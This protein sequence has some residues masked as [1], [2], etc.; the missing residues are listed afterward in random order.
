MA[1]PSSP[2][3]THPCT[4]PWKREDLERLRGNINLRIHFGISNIIPSKWMPP[5]YAK[6]NAV[7]QQCNNDLSRPSTAPVLRNIRREVQKPWRELSSNHSCYTLKAD[8]GGKT[9]IWGREDYR[10]EGLRQLGKT[11]SGSSARRRRKQPMPLSLT[12]KP[13]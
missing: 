8:K 6:Y 5:N 2:P 10:K 12:A 1:C 13:P 7:W 11:K 9:V 3:S 4:Q